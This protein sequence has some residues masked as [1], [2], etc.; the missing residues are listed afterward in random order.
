MRIKIGLLRQPCFPSIY[1][2]KVLTFKQ[3]YYVK[4]FRH[5][6]LRLYARRLIFFFAILQKFWAL[7][8]LSSPF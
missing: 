4:L 3:P 8:P 2:M 6:E 5:I 7:N 1:V